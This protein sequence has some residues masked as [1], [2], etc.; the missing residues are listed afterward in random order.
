MR[1]RRK[2]AIGQIDKKGNLDF[3]KGELEA[4]CKMHPNS[5]VTI[6][7][8]ILPKN[9]SDKLTNYYY[10]Y[11]VKEMASAIYESGERMTDEEVDAFLKANCPLRVDK[12]ELLDSAEQVEFVAWLQQ[13]AAENYYKIID[14]PI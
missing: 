10:G 11:V 14:D 2:V 9:P 13:W 6:E 4:F 7:V 8:K 3:Y 12:F 5:A 1:V